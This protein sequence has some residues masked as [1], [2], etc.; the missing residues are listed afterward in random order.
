MKAILCIFIVANAIMGAQVPDSKLQ[1]GPFCSPACKAGVVTIVFGGGC[2]LCGCALLT[3]ASCGGT[4]TA[5]IGATGLGMGGL[6][7]LMGHMCLGD[8]EKEKAQSIKQRT[9][10]IPA[11]QQMNDQHGAQGIMRNI[12]PA[13]DDDGEQEEDPLLAKKINT[14]IAGQ[15]SGV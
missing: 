11:L 3:H 1:D 9:P 4:A 5:V 15:S 14:W 10:T 13:P 12:S 2:C 6:S 7:C 8:A